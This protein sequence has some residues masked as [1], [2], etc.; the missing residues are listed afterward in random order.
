M[1]KVILTFIIG[2]LFAF[3]PY[4]FY[5]SITSP[6]YEL[7]SRDFEGGFEKDIGPGST[8]E[9][10]PTKVEKEILRFDIGL[11][12]NISYINSTTAQ[13]FSV[14]IYMDHKPIYHQA[15]V[16]SIVDLKVR[17]SF[18]R[19]SGWKLGLETPLHEGPDILIKVENKSDKSI[20][21][22]A[23]YKG[24]G[25]YREGSVI[26]FILFLLGF[27]MTIGSVLHSLTIYIRSKTEKKLR[28][29][30]EGAT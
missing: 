20:R 4:L 11:S 12:L 14:T 27:F 13:P 2:V 8:E 26:N 29:E 24:T 1:K 9:I 22:I 15:D 5:V 18:D 17:E 7:R 30:V 28:E 16:S 3:L 21:V 25:Y 10:W 19:F 23:Y 6:F